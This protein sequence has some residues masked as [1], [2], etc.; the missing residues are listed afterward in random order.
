MACYHPLTAYKGESGSVVFNPKAGLSGIPL[1]LP[2]G[3]CIGCR[4]ARARAWALRCVHEASLYEHNSFI[5]LTYDSAHLP[6]DGSV[7]VREWQLFAKKLRKMVGPFR[8]FHVGEYGEESFRPHYHA[9]LFGIDFSDNR[10]RVAAR[11]DYPLYMSETLDE[12]W[13]KGLAWI[14]SVSFQSAAYVARYCIKKVGGKVAAERYRR[15]DFST[16]EEWYVKPEYVTMSRGGRGGQGGIGKRWFEKY[17]SEVFPSDEVVHEGKKFR[18]PRY[19]DNLLDAD[20]LEAIKAKRRA[21][22]RG[23]AKD[24]TPERL[25]VRERCTSAKIGSLRRE[26]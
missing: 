5:T 18:P 9:L 21:K 22:V 23:F 12:A 20:A 10:Y 8:F 4:I 13:G 7:D 24:L 26:G 6:K 17:G 3:Q 1:L 11:G 2:C 16:G 19:Y 14:G 25:K 15:V